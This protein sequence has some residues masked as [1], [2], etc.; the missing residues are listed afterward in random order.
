MN[1]YLEIDDRHDCVSMA[2]KG[3]FLPKMYAGI[4]GQHA[5][6]INDRPSE[7]AMLR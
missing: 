7:N 2:W 5:G 1:S 6:S 3:G 4:A